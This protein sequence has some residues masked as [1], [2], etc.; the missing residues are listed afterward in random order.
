MVFKLKGSKTANIIFL[1]TCTF[2][3]QTPSVNALSGAGV[4]G[5]AVRTA[6]G[7]V[8]Y[9]AI[10]GASA[11]PRI[12]Q[13]K[14]MK[15]QGISVLSAA[16]SAASA[17]EEFVLGDIYVYPNP[18]KGGGVP[19]FHVESGLADSVKVKIYT[20][21]GRL[22]HEHVIAEFP[23]IISANGHTAYA[24][25]Y[26]WNGHIASGVYYYLIESEKAGRKLRRSGK[27]A[28]IR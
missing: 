21:A 16:P 15:K 26:A 4:S 24:Y 17:S 3:L 6:S 27:M 22:V 12:T 28:V 14:K 10:T 7:P 23:Q 18:A 8:K 2:I 1:G 5:G 9:A 19:V 11:A 20:V 25:E 13:G